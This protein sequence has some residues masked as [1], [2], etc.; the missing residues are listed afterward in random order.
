VVTILHAFA[1]GAADGKYPSSALTKGSDGYLYGTTGGGGAFDGGVAY[2]ISPSG[3]TLL[4]SFEETER[5]P[6]GSLIEGP[7]RN[8]YGLTFSLFKGGAFYVM[9]PAGAVTLL[10]TFDYDADDYLGD[11][12]GLTWGGGGNFYGVM[13]EG[14]FYRSGPAYEGAVFRIRLQGT[15]IGRVR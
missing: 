13:Q 6:H 9:T 8:F 7:D 14:P 4:H 2:R 12:D 5:Q 10:H 15:L 11:T 1:G 3:F